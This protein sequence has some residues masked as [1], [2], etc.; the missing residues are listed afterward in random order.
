MAILQK[1]S[2]ISRMILIAGASGRI[3]RRTAELLTSS[4]HSVRLMTRDPNRAPELVGAEVVRGDFAD[5]ATLD[6]AFR[7]I[8]TALI[9]SGSGQPGARA[10][11]HRNAFEAAA[12]A[13]V[14]HVIYLS[15]QGSSPESKYP[16]SR[17]HYQSE[18]FLAATDLPHTILRDAFYMDMF[19]ELFDAEGVIRGPA[20]EGRGAF[21][22]RE[23]VAL[24]AAAALIAK[25]GGTADVTGPEALTVAQVAARLSAIENRPL[26]FENESEVAARERLRKASTPPEKIDLSIGWFEAIAAG[27]LKHPSNTVLSLAGKKP[28]SLEEYFS[29]FPALIRGAGSEKDS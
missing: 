29:A 16:Y 2:A 11:T 5:P 3:G 28:M 7:G 20:G 26:R 15:L 19:L 1:R 18:Q 14:E 23:D 4:G 27:E 10:L 24:C 9:I 8:A 12:R 6:F 25:P 13:H 22:S 17:D 21:V